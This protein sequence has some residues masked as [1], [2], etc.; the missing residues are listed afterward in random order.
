VRVVPRELVHTA[1][2]STSFGFGG[3]DVSLVFVR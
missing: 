2:L 3:H 1:A